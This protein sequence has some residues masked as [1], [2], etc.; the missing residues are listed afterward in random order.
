MAR[1]WSSGFELNSATTN[2]EFTVVAG[3]P[4]IQATT[5]RSGGYAFEAN[6][7]AAQALAGF[8]AQASGGTNVGYL[9]SYIYVSSAPTTTQK[10][11]GFDNSGTARASVAMTNSRTIR[12]LQAGGTQVGSDSAA[13]ALNTWYRLEL[14]NDA[15]TSPGAVE[16]L[17]DGVSVASGADNTQGTWSGI[18]WGLGFTAAVTGNIVFDDFALNDNSG[19]FQTSY[20]GDGKI[21]H[22]NPDAAGDNSS[23]TRSA[24]SNNYANVNEIPPDD[25]TTYNYSSTLNGLDDYNLAASG[26]GASDIVNVVSVGTRHNRRA[27]AG[28]NGVMRTRIKKTSGGTVS[29]GANVTVSST[30]FVTSAENSPRVYQLTTYQDPDATDWTQ[31]TLDTMQIGV[32]IT[33][34]PSVGREPALSNIWALVDYTPSSS[35]FASVSDSVTVSEALAGY[36]DTI[37]TRESYA[38]QIVGSSDLSIS[39]SDTITISENKQVVIPDLYI[40]ASDTSN[41]SE[42]VGRL[43]TSNITASESVTIT[44]NRALII[45]DLYVN[46]SDTSTITESPSV[47]IQVQGSLTTSDNIS[48]SESVNLLITALF[49]SVSDGITVTESIA[50][51]PESYINRS[52]AVTVTE[53]RAFA[54]T[55]LNLAVSDTITLTENLS[56]LELVQLAVSD[57]LT[58]T[59]N[60]TAVI[61]TLNMSKSDSITVSESVSVF[62]D[63]PLTISVS[64]TITIS[65]AFGTNNFV[66]VIPYR[67]LRGPRG[68][69]SPAHPHPV[70]RKTGPRTT[71]RPRSY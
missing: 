54:V 26:I 30:I 1:I 50:T 53:S 23:W 13:L 62:K 58:I 16:L 35:P 70:H 24:G 36:S 4:T 12:L 28:S 5:V 9:R 47:F 49:L 25:V 41:I 38:V 39:T 57:Y 67:L 15:S 14:K 3:S 18:R 6:V 17:L 60:K 7:S 34:A 68:Y 21:I 48:V 63:A 11:L 59:E 71:R 45:P 64:D 66:V 55:P 22:L 46:V 69:N 52:D 37:Y 31:S 61:S 40:A 33:T 51:N 29:N 65:E 56:L 27:G 8:T 43:L 44:E 42:A 20:P 32:E 19:S 2:V 10:I